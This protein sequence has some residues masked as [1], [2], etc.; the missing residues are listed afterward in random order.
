MQEASVGQSTLDHHFTPS[1]TQINN[2]KWI[3]WV[4]MGGHTFS[5]VDD[6]MVRKNCNLKPICSK[7]L[8]AN[9]KRIKEYLVKLIANQLP[10]R[11]AIIFDGWS[12]GLGGHYVGI[13]ARCMIK[14]EIKNYLLCMRPFLDRASYKASDYAMLI[15][16][17]LTQYTKNIDNVVCIIADNC[18]TNVKAARILGVPLVGCASHR[19]A[20]FIKNYIYKDI[21]AKKTK[22][23]NE[24]NQNNTV[25]ND[26]N[27]NDDEDDDDYNIDDLCPM[28]N[29]DDDNTSNV[30]TGNFLTTINLNADDD[31]TNTS[32]NNSNYNTPTTTLHANTSILCTTTINNHI[33]MNDTENSISNISSSSSSS[34]SSI[35]DASA[36][37]I[38]I[39]VQYGAIADC[40]DNIDFIKNKVKV[41][42]TKMKTLKNAD[43]LKK[44]TNLKP[45][46]NN[47]TRWLSTYN[48][49]HR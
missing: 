17:V 8:K 3:R 33:T 20:L 23:L 4:V 5:F 40:A 22:T 26:D 37:G 43:T 10:D 36:Y 41:L 13:F 25:N 11:F 1:E 28:D 49:L 9:I 30:N 45:V 46:I 34:S 12:D 16:H 14:A 35:N 7:T 38:D 27:V 18:T 32:N 42:M 48:M 39:T 6:T 47:V 15:L 29:D 2:Y 31:D 21:P 19:L 24:T 44:H